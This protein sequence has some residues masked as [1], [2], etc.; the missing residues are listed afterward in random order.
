MYID[1]STFHVLNVSIDVLIFCY[2]SLT[3][4]LVG[5]ERNF[6]S[7]DED[8][9]S[10]ELCVRILSDP[11]S[12]PTHTDLSF[13]LDL[14]TLSATA[15]TNC[16]LAL[17]TEQ[18]CVIC[19]FQ[20]ILDSSDYVEISSSNNP[21]VPF[22]SDPTTHRQCFNVTITDDLVLEDTEFFSLS[23]SLAGG[24]TIPV[25]I[26]PSVSTVEITDNDGN[27]KSFATA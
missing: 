14:E 8:V 21:L 27:Q 2:F 13:S 12:F 26:S 18:L 6:T 20:C 23:L 17:E 5:F 9:G 15:G 4:I 24:S 1:D 22:T 19:L 3:V 10:F 7:V 25:T 16:M 11:S